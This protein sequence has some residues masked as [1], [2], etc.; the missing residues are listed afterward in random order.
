MTI[1][2][3]SAQGGVLM[4]HGYTPTGIPV[5]QAQPATLVFA[6]VHAGRYALH[7]HGDDGSHREVAALEILP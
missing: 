1:R 3:T 5:A 2:A 4:I 6:A 7:L